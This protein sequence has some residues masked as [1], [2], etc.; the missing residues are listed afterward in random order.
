M[1]A[2]ATIGLFAAVSWLAWSNGANDNFKGVATLYG[3]GTTTFRRALAF[4]TVAT[5][6]GSIV[7]VYL[8]DMLVERF[9]GAGIVSAEQIDGG[10]LTAVGAA[11]AATIFLAT[12]L[13]MPTSTT[14]ALTGSLVGAAMAAGP[15]GVNWGVVWNKFAQ[16]LLLSPVV[17]ICAATVLYLIL[18]RARLALGVERQTCLC[19]GNAAPQPVT[20]QQ[21][22]SVVLAAS[23]PEGVRI[24]I[25][26]DDR[27]M[28]RYGRNGVGVH[29]QGAMDAVHY[30]TAGAVCF[31][32]AVNDTPKI[33]AL[34]LA[35]GAVTGPMRTAVPLGV[36]AVAMALGGLVQTR[37]VAET[38]SRGIT[39][40]NPGQ[41]LTASLVTSA[42]VL[43]A[44][45]FGMPV[46]T[47]HVSCGSIFGVGLINRG[48]QW[49]TVAGIATTWLTTL[50]MGALLGALF[51]RIVRAIM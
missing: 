41:G 33:A 3:G 6:L 4:A 36:V 31:A 42:L 15:T 22:G 45:R 28:E 5:L 27:C 21:D 43:A 20:V 50:P 14:H 34:M 9:S 10:W 8:A 2:T 30:V 17:A 38:M 18:H 32:R 40:L 24:E 46:S 29:A 35:A 44:S 47:T 7:S 51:Y 23:G 1:T 49:K 19:I 11:G 39:G 37:K 13:G 25:G 16:P 48:M 12:I 26:E